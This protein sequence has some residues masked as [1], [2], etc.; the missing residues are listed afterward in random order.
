MR[1]TLE[2]QSHGLIS[3]FHIVCPSV[4]YLWFA[5]ISFPLFGVISFISDGGP[6]LLGIFFIPFFLGGFV[7]MLTPYFEYQRQLATVYVITNKRVISICGGQIKSYQPDELKGIYRKEYRDGSGDVIFAM[8]WHKDS[9]GKQTKKEIGFFN[10]QNPK[11]AEDK[12][13]KLSSGASCVLATSTDDTSEI[14]MAE[15]MLEPVHNRY[16]CV[17]PTATE[18]AS[19]T[20]KGET[21]PESLHEKHFCNVTFPNQRDLVQTNVQPI[22]SQG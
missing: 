17:L 18:D 20:I 14:I 9:D 8:E 19:E 7:A 16:F 10:I 6:Y 21:I 22:L 5:F 4:A 13:K 1:W 2:R 3:P 15:A 12:I 11:E